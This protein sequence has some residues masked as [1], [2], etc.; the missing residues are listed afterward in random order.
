[1]SHVGIANK[2]LFVAHLLVISTAR[3]L[4]VTMYVIWYFF[5]VIETNNK[6]KPACAWAKY[7]TLLT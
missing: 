2:V 4:F 3:F 6:N 5:M 7:T 1:M